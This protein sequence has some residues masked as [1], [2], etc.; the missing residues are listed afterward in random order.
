MTASRFWHP[1]L[2]SILLAGA[3]L[4]PLAPSHA[5]EKAKGT[6][7]YKGPKKSFSV[8]LKHVCL[9]KG[10]DMFDEKKTIRRLVFTADDFSKV[11]NEAD[12]LNAFDGKLMEGIIIELSDGPR[13]NY[14]LVLNNQLVQTSGTVDLVALKSTANTPTRLAGKITFDD[15]KSDGPKMNVEFDAPLLKSFA[16]AR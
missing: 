9:V 12:A 4:V 15:S 5:G 3:L 14:W 1:T 6:V 16:K 2:M 8:D 7:T 10:P 11:I 13:L